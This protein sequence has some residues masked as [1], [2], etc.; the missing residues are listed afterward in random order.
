MAL[1]RAGGKA[2][3]TAGRMAAGGG[4]DA[5]GLLR[6]LAIIWLQFRAEATLHWFNAAALW[7]VAALGVLLAGILIEGFRR[8][9]AAAL[10]ALVPILLLEFA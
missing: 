6:K 2:L 5:G 4:G 7:C 9:R 3:D 8:D 1:V 10:L